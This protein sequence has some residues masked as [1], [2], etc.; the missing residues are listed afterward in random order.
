MTPIRSTTSA[1]RRPTPPGHRLRRGGW[2]VACVLATALLAACSGGA[3][4]DAGAP[5]RR[6]LSHK[7]VYDV[8]VPD[9][10]ARAENLYAAAGA[11]VAPE[12]IY[13]SSSGDAIQ[14]LVSGSSDIAVGVSLPAVY[15]A[16]Q[17]GADIAIVSAEFQ[18]YGDIA[19]YVPAG[20]PLQTLDDVGGRSVSTS[21]PGSSTDLVGRE[22]GRQLEAAGR[23]APEL[24]ALGNP[25]DVFTA[26]RTGQVDVG[27]TTPP[28]F[29]DSVQDGTLRQIGTGNDV[30]ELSGITSRVNITRTELVEQR[31]PD[32]Q[33][34]F[35][36]YADAIAFTETDPQRTL[37]IWKEV[38]ELDATPEVLAEAQKVYPAADLDP[39]RLEGLDVSLRVAHELGFISE[40]LS[41]E[42]LAPHLAVD[43]VFG[44]AD[45][46]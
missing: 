4:G 29:L 46:G 39:R 1:V 11:N 10:V 15:S 16:I 2:A 43:A 17:Q 3:A 23:P 44:T 13:P 18:G 5:L 25:S 9:A 33:A 41:E 36:A 28:F 34:F 35:R 32:L 6:S 38:S 26:V 30:E 21:G 14:A 45:R 27:W 31:L 20:S 42:E 7:V 40:P 22:L 12:P 24:A 37:E 8:A 19:Y